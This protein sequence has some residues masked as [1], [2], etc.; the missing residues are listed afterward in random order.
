MDASLLSGLVALG[1]NVIDT[2][3]MDFGDFLQALG[4]PAAHAAVTDDGHV[5]DFSHEKDLQVRDYFDWGK[6]YIIVA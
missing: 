5:H 4:M 2:G 6:I 1:E 3:Q